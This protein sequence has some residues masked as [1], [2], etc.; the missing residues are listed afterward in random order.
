MALSRVE[1]LL[2]KT[3][4][5][6]KLEDYKSTQNNYVREIIYLLLL[7]QKDTMH[8]TLGYHHGTLPRPVLDLL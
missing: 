8:G 7:R 3:R 6:S 2:L 1:G 5:N 4:L